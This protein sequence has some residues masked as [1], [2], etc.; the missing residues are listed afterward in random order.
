LTRLVG[1]RR[2]A[3][4]ALAFGMAMAGALVATPAQAVPGL[5]D[6]TVGS[7]NDSTSPKTV[8]VNCPAG[9]RLYGIPAELQGAFGNVTLDDV[10]PNAALTS[11]T[12]TAYENGAYAS[13]W[14]LLGRAIC[15]SPTAGLQRVFVNS[16]SNS[17]SPKTVTAAC[18]A[19]TRL[20]GL[21]GQLTGAVGNV[22]FDD[23]T[24]SSGLTSATMTAYENGAYAS[25]WQ[26]TSYAICA[27]PAATMVRITTSTVSD[28]NSP[29]S[30]TSTCPN[31]TDVHGIGG[32]LNGAVG[33]VVIDGIDTLGG[34]LLFGDV[35]AYE[36]GAYG[37]N[38][39]ATAYAI[40]AS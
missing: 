1:G 27:N 22:F 33:N 36:N 13:S 4:V 17:T 6:V 5:V 39:S 30:V 19:G 37:S 7:A 11:A 21:G 38:W 8:T 3:A 14:R 35:S 23:M 16:A 2:R 18:P 12:V 25:N 15:G 40:C 31:G 9:T 29:K 20:Y 28:S 34:T 26:L 32:E 24:P 10:T